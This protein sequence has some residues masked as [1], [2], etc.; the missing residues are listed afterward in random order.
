MVLNNIYI[1]IY[2]YIVMSGSTL[3]G[4]LDLHN[5]SLLYYAGKN[6]CIFTASWRGTSGAIFWQ[7]FHRF[8][9]YYAGPTWNHLFYDNLDTFAMFRHPLKINKYATWPR[10]AISGPYIMRE[11]CVINGFQPLFDFQKFG[12]ASNLYADPVFQNPT[13]DIN[14][15]S[16]T[17]LYIRY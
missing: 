8:E 13:P 9:N 10:L 17:H 5:V 4:I 14:C 1:Y 11:S 15:Y 16:W 2:I 7:Q 6:N 12:C 3:D